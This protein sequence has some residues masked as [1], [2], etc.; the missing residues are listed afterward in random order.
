MP[1]LFERLTLRIMEIF[2]CFL[3]IGIGLVLMILYFDKQQRRRINKILK[4]TRNVQPLFMLRSTEQKLSMLNTLLHGNTTNGINTAR[5]NINESARELILSQ[6]AQ[7]VEDYDN[8]KI[9]IK[10]YHNKLNELLITV[11]GVKEF[12]FEPISVVK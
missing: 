10:N 9:T 3:A 8:G 4:D 2:F 12:R 1:K 6:L 7:L 5:V 11:N